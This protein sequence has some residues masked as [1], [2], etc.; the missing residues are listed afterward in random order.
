MRSLNEILTD[1][2]QRSGLTLEQ[3]EEQAQRRYFDTIERMD[4]LGIASPFPTELPPNTQ[5]TVRSGVSRDYKVMGKGFADVMTVLAA[6]SIELDMKLWLHVSLSR[7]DRIPSYQDLCFVKKWWIGE[8]GTAIQVFPPA[9]QHV[10]DHPN[11]L[12]LWSPLEGSPLPD[13]RKFGTI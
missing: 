8:D 13:F 1:I 5:E 2:Q 7:R 6:V 12:H 11:C 9:S 3:M 4:A 10:S